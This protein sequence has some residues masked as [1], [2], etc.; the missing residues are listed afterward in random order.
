MS[1]VNRIR[2]QV[3]LTLHPDTVAWM[4]E[5]A[6]LYGVDKSKVADLAMEHLHRSL[7]GERKLDL[8]RE[9]ASRSRVS[10]TQR[11]KTDDTPTPAK[12]GDME[13]QGQLPEAI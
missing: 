2:P 12:T 13:I 1:K 11:Q 7:A 5:L 9:M 3:T 10:L 8:K 4:D 6:N